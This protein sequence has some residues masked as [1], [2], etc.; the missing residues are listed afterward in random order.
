M[1]IKEMNKTQKSKTSS[2]IKPPNSSRNKFDKNKK[3]D[4]NGESSSPKKNKVLSLEDKE[5]EEEMEMEILLTEDNINTNN[6][7][8]QFLS[9]DRLNARKNLSSGKVKRNEEDN[10]RNIMKNP[11]TNTFGNKI[12]AKRL[13]DLIH[14]DFYNKYTNTNDVDINELKNQIYNMNNSDIK[15]T[16]NKSAV[17]K[18]EFK[19]YNKYNN[20]TDGFKL[21]KNSFGKNQFVK[22]TVKNYKENIINLL[23]TTKTKSKKSKQ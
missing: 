1:K 19:E 18:T 16:I 17:K 20:N 10:K 3:F 5:E 21:I 2:I 9:K 6:K 13:K 14:D 15:S 22:T 11:V 8:K 4:L 23:E 12:P 7:K